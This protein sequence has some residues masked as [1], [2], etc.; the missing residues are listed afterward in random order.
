M[1]GVRRASGMRPSD[2]APGAAAPSP[3]FRYRPDGVG[4]EH[5]TGWIGA[6]WVD[7]WVPG[8]VGSGMDRGGLGRWM[9]SAV[10]GQVGLRCQAPGWAC[11]FRGAG[12]C[13]HAPPPRGRD[14]PR[15]TRTRPHTARGSPECARGSRGRGPGRRPGADPAQTPRR[16]SS[17]P[18]VRPQ[19]VKN[20][21]RIPHH[22]L[23]TTAR[24]AHSPSFGAERAPSKG[25]EC[26]WS[27]ASWRGQQSSR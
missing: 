13:R 4:L 27:S 16:L 22:L 17:P 26:R 10:D 2:P 1:R 21:T 18:Q 15:P 5:R 8:W 7:G 11:P 12:L 24:G 20:A 14:Q 23:H 3:P 25:G 9:G 6:A 19:C